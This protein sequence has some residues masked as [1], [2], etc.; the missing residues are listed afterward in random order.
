[1]TESSV[2]FSRVKG[3]LMRMLPNSIT[4]GA[5]RKWLENRYKDSD[6][7]E[8]TIQRIKLGIEEKPKCAT[9]GKPVKFNV[10]KP[11]DEFDK[12]CSD[13]CAARNLE[14]IAKKQATDR[15]HHGG[16]TGWVLSNKDPKKIA[17]RRNTLIEK[18]HTTTLCDVPEIAE[19]I[20]KTN[21]E[22]FGE[23]NAMQN[24]DIREKYIHAHI[25]GT[26]QEETEV[27]Y[28]LK[29]YYP[30]IIHFYTSEV[31]PF[32][33]DFYIPEKDLYIE[34]EGSQYHHRHAF[35]PKNEEDIAEK[36]HLEEKIEEL[37]KKEPNTQNQYQN[38]LKTW[39]VNDPKKR[40]I[41]KRN[42]LNFFEIWNMKNLDEDIRKINEFPDI[43]P[44]IYE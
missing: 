41:V 23:L 20:R 28:F 6:S 27:Y 4:S 15:K 32:N 35:N 33:C 24:R 1:M 2:I 36:K 42:H 11:N 44:F 12:Y 7:I 17:K 10:E 18:Y 40:M 14:V 16:Q 37:I 38:M 43:H 39:T 25:P 34:Y 22:R 3:G 8:E 13:A 30:H 26:S 9:C 5:L 29:K 31:Y 19:K 21:M